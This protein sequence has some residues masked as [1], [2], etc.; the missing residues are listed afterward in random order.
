MHRLG[1]PSGAAAGDGL[2]DDAVQTG[3]SAGTRDG[4][5]YWILKTATYMDHK[6][7]WSNMPDETHR[8]LS[9]PEQDVLAVRRKKTFNGGSCVSFMCVARGVKCVC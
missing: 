2:L 9:I 5:G 1:R 8:Q 7:Q 3:T 4:S 6:S